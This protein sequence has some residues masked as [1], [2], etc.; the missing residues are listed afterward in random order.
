MITHFTAQRIADVCEEIDNCNN[1]VDI[2]ENTKTPII[3]INIA[4]NEEDEGI[5]I[6]LSPS[7]TIE[8]IKK[9]LKDLRT[10]QI[11]LNEKAGREITK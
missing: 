4:A 8:A 11:A 9:Q 2:F 1:A 7:I 3:N 5:T 10:E 6:Q